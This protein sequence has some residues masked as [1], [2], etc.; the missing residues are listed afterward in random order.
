MLMGMDVHQFDCHGDGYRASQG[1]AVQV[2]GGLV[3]GGRAPRVSRAHPCTMGC[4]ECPFTR[5]PALW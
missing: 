3:A 2:V 4:P 1:C 5:P